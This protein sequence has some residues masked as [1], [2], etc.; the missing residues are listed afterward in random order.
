M[1]DMEHMKRKLDLLS[2][3]KADIRKKM[4]LMQ[5]EITKDQEDIDQ[6]NIQ[7][8]KITGTKDEMITTTSVGDAATP[9]GSANFAPKMSM[10]RRTRCDDEDKDKCK[11]YKYES[12]ID[13]WFEGEK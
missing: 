2:R 11:K 9:G 6:I 8:E 12:F 10:M 4:D 7:I 3:K 13:H 1:P 5:A